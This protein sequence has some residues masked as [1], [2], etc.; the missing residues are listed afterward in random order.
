MEGRI[1]G[2]YNTMRSK[3]VR[4]DAVCFVAPARKS[5]RHLENTQAAVEK[6]MALAQLWNFWGE[7]ACVATAAAQ[8]FGLGSS[9]GAA[10]VTIF[11]GSRVVERL[12]TKRVQSD[13]DTVEEFCR[14][15]MVLMLIFLQ[16]L[17]GYLLVCQHD[18]VFF[19][20]W[21][22]IDVFCPVDGK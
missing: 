4:I 20:P 17:T 12:R 3:R 7:F 21:R 11:F 18:L 10:G 19:W 22:Q 5:V 9:R 2:E 13:F 8:I 15:N 1:K 16:K 6:P 14:F